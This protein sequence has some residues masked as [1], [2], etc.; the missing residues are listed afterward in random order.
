MTKSETNKLDK[1]WGLIV[2][3]RA[4]DK[5]E[6]CGIP[7]NNPH[8][9]I[10]RRNKNVRWDT[11]NGFCLCYGCHSMRADSAHQDGD[12]FSEWAKKKRGDKWHKDLR[13]RSNFTNKP[14]YKLLRIF[15]EKELK[16]YES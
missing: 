16:K 11:D 8:H 5:C 3:A 2:R 1:L 13:L 7:G 10:G 14:D 15:L 4:K 12:L 9:F 6:R